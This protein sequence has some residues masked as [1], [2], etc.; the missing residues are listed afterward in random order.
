M[1]QEQDIKLSVVIPVYNKQEYLEVCMKS[2]FAQDL[3]GIEAIAVDDGST[4]GS[5]DNHDH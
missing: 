2:V 5:G 3:N 4:G 1:K